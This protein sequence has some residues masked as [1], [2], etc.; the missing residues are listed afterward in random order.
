M[1]L[2]YKEKYPEIGE[3]T[4]LAPGSIIIG[5][6]TIGNNC[7]VW[8]NAVIRA[9]L[10]DITIGNNTNVQDG[11][12]VHCDTNGPTIVGDNVTL[13]HNS[14]IHGCKIGNNCIIGM[15]STVMKGAVIGE[16]TI[17]GANSLVTVGKEIPAGS[18]VMG[19]PAKVVRP[20]TE[21][22]IKGIA[23]SALQYIGLKNEHMKSK[24]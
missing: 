5:P 15:G 16:N 22:E 21:T 10:S 8:Y 1:L 23:A 13:G 19:S 6:C 4:F 3:N 20:L 14:I 24:V 11:T 18:M 2:S 7:G 12:I 9:D 17:V